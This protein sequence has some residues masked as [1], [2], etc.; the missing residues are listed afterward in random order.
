MALS[1]VQVRAKAK[2]FVDALAGMPRSAHALA[3]RG[4]F[5]RDYND[6]RELA[7]EAAPALNVRLLGKFV[8]VRQDSSGEEISEASFVEIEAYARQIMEQLTLIIPPAYPPASGVTLARPVQSDKPPAQAG[9]PWTPAED[10][11]LARAFESGHSV[12]ELAKAHGRTEG[13][14][15]NRL[16]RQGKFALASGAGAPPKPVGRGDKSAWEV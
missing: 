1:I 5:G 4:H 9:K 3:P 16:E 7:L 8:P 11:K 14:I 13:A 15:R 10:N 2:A 12:I 6:L